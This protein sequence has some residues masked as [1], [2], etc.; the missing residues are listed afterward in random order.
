MGII[1]DLSASSFAVEEAKSWIKEVSFFSMISNKYEVQKIYLRQVKGQSHT[2][3]MVSSRTSGTGEKPAFL[4]RILDLFTRIKM[5]KEGI[6][7]PLSWRSGDGLKN[8]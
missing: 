1:S 8:L 6:W 7:T 2:S 5:E 3:L 4:F